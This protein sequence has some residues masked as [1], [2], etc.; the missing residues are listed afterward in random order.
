MDQL[1][2]NALGETLEPGR[3]ADCASAAPAVRTRREPEAGSVLVVTPAALLHPGV[4]RPAGR[5]V[6]ALL[7]AISTGAR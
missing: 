7:T 6:Y 5:L 4:P 2:P 1:G 3:V